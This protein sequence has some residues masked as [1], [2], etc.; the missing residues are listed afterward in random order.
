MP[1]A[2]DT[3]LEQAIEALRQ[4]DKAR[5]KEAKRNRKGK[6]STLTATP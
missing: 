2:V 6:D 5:A 3:M 1:E 4:Y